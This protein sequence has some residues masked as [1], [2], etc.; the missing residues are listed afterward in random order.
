[1]ALSKKQRHALKLADKRRS[2]RPEP[3]AQIAS[4]IKA[5]AGERNFITNTNPKVLLRL[6]QLLVDQAERDESIDDHA[7]ANSLRCCIQQKSPQSETIKPIVSAI[8]DWIDLEDDD[9]TSNL[10]M[11]VVYQSIKRRS[12]CKPGDY[13]YLMYASAFVKQTQTRIAS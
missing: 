13:D 2:R 11:R 1:M 6:E 8:A 4:P 5:T 12:N 7:I 10:A 9:E 3:T